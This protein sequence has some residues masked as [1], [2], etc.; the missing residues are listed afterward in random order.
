M[1]YWQRFEFHWK[2]NFIVSMIIFWCAFF[3]F[4]GINY[5]QRYR[6]KENAAAQLEVQL[7]NAKACGAAHAA[8]P[9]LPV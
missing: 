4:R 1:A 6:E 7:A 9:A 3:L 2:A 8:K 5:Y